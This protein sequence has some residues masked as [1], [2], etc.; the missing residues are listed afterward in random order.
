[1]AGFLSLGLIMFRLKLISLPST[2][3]DF[4]IS[5]FESQYNE[6]ERSHDEFDFKHGGESLLAED[7]FRVCQTRSAQE[8]LANH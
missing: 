7:R 4:N 3:L 8:P 5:V 6:I 1:M 2:D